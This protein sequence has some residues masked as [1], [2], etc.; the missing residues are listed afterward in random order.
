MVQVPQD[1][2]PGVQTMLPATV[3]VREFPTHPYE[4]IVAHMAGALD[5]SSRTMMV[6]VRVPNPDGQLLTGM[7][8]DVA[9]KLPTPHRL[10]E[11]PVTALYSDAR[12]SRVATVGA[13]GRV[14]MKTVGIER[15]TGQTLQIATG[16]DGSER[17]VKLA[18][19]GLT[20]GSAVEVMAPPTKTAVAPAK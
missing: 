2:A 5:D 13:E 14:L 4:G 9:L 20:D 17:I 19:A 1:V 16:L 7:Y 18:N 11:I 12:G 6:E 8:A 3:T 15:D 10:F